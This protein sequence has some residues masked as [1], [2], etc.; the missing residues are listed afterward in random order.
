V[1]PDPTRHPSDTV[2]GLDGAGELR[3]RLAD[4]VRED[5]G[6]IEGATD[7]VVSRHQTTGRAISLASAVLKEQGTEQLGLAASGA[8]F[9]LVISALPTATAAVN[10]FGLVVAPQQ[11]AGD[12]GHLA[13]T[14][15]GSVGSLIA[16]QL[17]RIAAADHAGLTIGLAVSLALAVWTASAGIYNLDR[18]VRDAYGLPRQRYADAR[19]RAFGGAFVVV[20]SLGAVAF[21]TS[22]ELAHS[23]AVLTMVVGGPIVFV[24]TTAGVC[25]LY[26]FAVGQPKRVRALLP[27]A[28]GSATG[29][30][31]LLAGFGAYAALSTHYAAI[32]GSFAG[33]VV[34]ML[35][36]YLAVY[37]VLLGAVLN[38]EI[39]QRGEPSDHVGVL[40]SG[41][42]S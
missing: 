29:T 4:E 27:G 31:L 15:P 12:L 21:A 5:V 26:R 30:V 42:P 9:W 8:A 3:D 23:P 28:L 10:L 11:V 17:R 41:S 20:V 39:A 34:V 32:Y 13:S 16:D 33:A 19:A 35:A 36:T 38:V 37:A 7:L 2:A 24:A 18:A 25:G 40:G 22:A 14:A 6:A 1:S